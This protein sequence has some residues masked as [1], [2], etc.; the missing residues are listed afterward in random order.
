MQESVPPG[1]SSPLEKETVQ[2]TFGGEP[3]VAVGWV[4]DKKLFH[5]QIFTPGRADLPQGF[6]TQLVMESFRVEGWKDV[7]L[8]PTLDVR[9]VTPKALEYLSHCT[10]RLEISQA[11]LEAVRS[12]AVVTKVMYLTNANNSLAAPNNGVTTFDR[13]ATVSS[14]EL[15]TTADPLAIAEQRGP[16]V[17]VFRMSNQSS[18]KTANRQVVLKH[19]SLGSLR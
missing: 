3:A 13:C 4:S 7:S 2:F 12:N 10:V 9:E 19:K 17:A 1:T 5:N 18:Q 8:F 15:G 11:D 6:T 16:I 14:V